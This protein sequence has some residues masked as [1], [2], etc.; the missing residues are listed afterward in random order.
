M[1]TPANFAV[2]QEHVHSS[3]Y[4]DVTGGMADKVRHMIDL[5]NR[6]PQLKVRIIT[7]LEPDNLRRALL[8]PDDFS[9]GTLICAPLPAS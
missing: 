3:G 4:T 9:G 7:G 5:V 6:F 8:D 1:I 2:F